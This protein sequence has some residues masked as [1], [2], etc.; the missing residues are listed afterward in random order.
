MVNTFMPYSDFKKVAQCLDYRR[1]GKQR[2]EVWQIYRV[3][4]G[5]SDGWVNHPATKM[6]KGHEVGLLYYGICMCEEWIRRGYN[7]TMLPRF[8]EEFSKITGEN[9]FNVVLI[10]P[11]SLNYKFPDWVY[12]EKSQLAYKS[13]LIRKDAEFYTKEFGDIPNDLEYTWG[14]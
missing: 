5:Q 4:T 12:D 7:D 11:Y 9:D 13:N 1:L 8:K 3:L 10:G 2:V 14:K 6:W